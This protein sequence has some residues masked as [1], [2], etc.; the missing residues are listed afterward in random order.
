MDYGKLLSRAWNII[1]NNKFMMVL[2]FLA[3]LGAGG[4]GTNFNFNLGGGDFDLPPGVAQ[5]LERMLEQMAPLFVGLGCLV[6]LLGIAVWLLRLAAQAGM[7]DAAARIDAGEKMTFGRAFNAGLARL[8]P[9]VGLNLVLF[10]FF[11]ILGIVAL[12]GL[13]AT[14]GVAVVGALAGDGNLEAMIAGFGL[15]L[16]CVGL[17]VCVSIPLYTIVAVIYPFA[18]RGLVLQNLGVMASISHGWNMIKRNLGDVL[19]LIVLFVF[20][21]IVVGFVTAL[22]LIPLAVL[23]M[24]PALF[25]MLAAGAVG[26]G[27]V[28]TLI[29]GGICLGILAA[30][31]NAI[32][33]AFRSTTVTL[34]YQE[35]LLR[36]Q[37]AKAVWDG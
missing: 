1:W 2:G 25:N 19:I 22:V 9:M 20:L 6:L 24:G 31:V 4:G 32:L 29:G 11:I 5:N 27:S 13:I 8:L 30:I 15:I 36:D 37:P 34:A 3:A 28:L 26:I 10:G 14:V 35:F 12:V 7:I 21:Q 18:Q 33:V 23:V 17:L 16:V